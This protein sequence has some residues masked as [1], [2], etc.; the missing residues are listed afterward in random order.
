MCQHCQKLKPIYIE[1][2]KMVQ[3]DPD[4]TYMFADV[5]TLSQ[6][7]LGKHFEIKGLP[8]IM[9]F[10]PVNDY[11]PTTYNG[12][13]T[14]FSLVTEIELASGLSN[15][16][17]ATFSD[18][19]YR[20]A[21]RDENII[22]G[23]FKDRKDPLFA[24]MQALKEEFQFVRMY[25]TFN[26]EEFRGK[27]K[28]ADKA[29]GYVLMLHN[30]R[31]LE[32]NDSPYTVYSKEKFGSLKEFLIRKYPYD[33]DCLDDKVA[34]IYGYRHLPQA[35]LFTSFVNRSKEVRDYA[36]KM[37]PLGRKFEG[38]LNVY[39]QDAEPRFIRKYRLAGD[40]TYIIFD[41]D[42]EKSKYRFKAKVFNGSVDVDALIAFTQDFMDKKAERYIR[43]AELNKDD[44]EEPV[45][46]VVAKTYDE[47]VKNPNK[48]VFIRF[49]D[50]MVQRFNDQF[51]MRKEWWKVGRNL[52]KN[53]KD[54]VICEIEIN[55]NDVAEYF[56][57]EMRNNHYYF[58]FTKKQKARPYI[59]KGRVNA[60]DMIKFA[61]DTIA[62]EE[63]VKVDL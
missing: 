37:K 13:R 3:D 12:N 11:M 21:R 40:A 34:T 59:Y 46:P 22:L 48:H 62:Q 33:V 28:I 61:E 4:G 18:L 45:Y 42:F 52:T 58:L 14:V 38:K 51:L 25:Y 50:K 49:F 31:Y 9:I 16:E 17:L 53:A 63:K 20:L 56:T 10:S 29:D 7:K 24:Q 43:S 32:D 5:N 36:R 27:L 26:F 30:K 35:V 54:L 57:N 15:R 23:V 19:E 44:L 39:L 1:A 41:T 55:D 47:V 2:A 8:T 6:E 60:T